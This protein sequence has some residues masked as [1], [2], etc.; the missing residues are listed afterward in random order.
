MFQNPGWENYT[1][2]LLVAIGL[3]A[4]VVDIC[5]LLWEKYRWDFPAV[6]GI[7][8]FFS[9]VLVFTINPVMKMEYLISYALWAIG[10]LT[11]FIPSVENESREA[12]RK[13]Q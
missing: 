5:F 12:L 6:A 4:L 13:L 1:V 3:G 9:G 7:I 11:I 8:L 2:H 10:S